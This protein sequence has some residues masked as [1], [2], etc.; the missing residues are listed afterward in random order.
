MCKRARKKLYHNPSIFFPRQ[1]YIS[2]N[3]FIPSSTYTIA[4]LIDGSEFV[5]ISEIPTFQNTFFFSFRFSSVLSPFLSANESAVLSSSIVVVTP[6]IA[7][8]FLGGRLPNVG[9]CSDSGGGRGGRSNS[10]FSG[11]RSVWIMLKEP[12]RA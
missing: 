3:N 4:Y 8:P 1:K 9:G 12:D 11:F 2:C 6:L 7:A 5:N 10:T